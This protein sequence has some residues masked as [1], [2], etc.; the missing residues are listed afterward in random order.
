MP[1]EQPGGSERELDDLKGGGEEE[2]GVGVG[3]LL[4]GLPQT[5][6][7]QD[8]SRVKYILLCRVRPLF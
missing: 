5:S 8:C 2:A 4:S 7:F 6:V 3:L 1:P